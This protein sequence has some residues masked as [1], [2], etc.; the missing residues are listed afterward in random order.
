MIVA[1]GFLCL[2][3]CAG[4]VSAGGV[5]E[6]EWNNTYYAGLYTDLF[7]MAPAGDGGY[8]FGGLGYDP[9]S[10]G[11]NAAFF[12]TDD[13]G[14][15][16]WNTA[17]EGFKVSSIAAVGDGTFVL[18]T[19]TENQRFGETGELISAE[20]SSHLIKTDGEG[21]ALWD[22]SVANLIV[23]KVLV[24]DGGDLMICGW[25]WYDD[26]TTSA[27]L[28]K[29]SGDGDLVW[30]RVLCSGAAYDVAQAGTGYFVAGVDSLE[31]IE[32]AWLLKTT[33]DGKQT[34]KK[35]YE[36]LAFYAMIPD[37]E[38]YL[39]TG[40]ALVPF[41]ENQMET[42]AVAVKTDSAGMKLW[43]QTLQG[44]AGYDALALASDEYVIAG[45]W[46]DAAM[47]LLLDENGNELDS[48]IYQAIVDN[49]SVASIFHVVAPAADGGF[50]TAGWT[51][52]GGETAEGWL[53]KYAPP[54]GVVVPETTTP[55]S[56]VTTIA[57]PQG[58]LPVPSST[59]A[60]G[61]GVISVL[62]AL[63]SAGILLRRRA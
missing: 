15:V 17:F 29:Y 11:N 51:G 30:E 49:S 14:T 57:T 36:N 34:S 19:T 56:A 9:A 59:E 31:N 13:A 18:T 12:R 24:N 53:V 10:G 55:T 38:E 2:C 45:K 44:A 7:A 42:R 58:T 6:E 3:A 62:A 4:S 40:S 54:S 41:T 32:T 48:A 28:V 63:G 1:V 16:V 27:V 23:R 26:L 33:A 50:A 8:L 43:Q 21:T 5:V 35:T 37:G 60:P 20:G 46:G 25:R 47:T 22:T 39:L 61:F 52:M